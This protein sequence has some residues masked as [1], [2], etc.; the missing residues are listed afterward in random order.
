V[1]PENASDLVEAGATVLVA[2]ASIFEAP[3][4]AEAALR[5][6]RQAIE[7]ARIPRLP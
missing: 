4:G 3:D 1:G 5:R 6:L 7:S 2:G